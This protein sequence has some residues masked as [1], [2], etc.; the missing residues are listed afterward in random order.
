MTKLW[1]GVLAVALVVAGDARAQCPPGRTCGP[2]YDVCVGGR[3]YRVCPSVNPAAWDEFQRLNTQRTCLRRAQFGFEGRETLLALSR[4]EGQMV[5]VLFL[6]QL[7]SGWGGGFGGGCYPSF[8]VSPYPSPYSYPAEQQLG[9][10]QSPYVGPIAPTYPPAAGQLGG[11]GGQGYGTPPR[12]APQQQPYT[13]APQGG[14]GPGWGP[15]ASNGPA[16]VITY[17]SPLR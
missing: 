2:C 5:Q 8:P 15:Q 11:T 7:R 14:G 10:Y 1:W 9:P 16:G 13:P 4:L 17:T 6:L 3:C 12:L